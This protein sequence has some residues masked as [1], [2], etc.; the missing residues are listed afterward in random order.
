MSIS[1][2]WEI[3]AQLSKTATLYYLLLQ[4]GFSRML[5]TNRLALLFRNSL[6]ILMSSTLLDSISKTV[7]LLRE[8]PIFLIAL[9]LAVRIFNESPPVNPREVSSLSLMVSTLRFS[10][11]CRKYLSLLLFIFYV[12]IYLL[13]F[14]EGA[15]RANW[16]RLT[17]FDWHSHLDSAGRI[18]YS[19]CGLTGRYL[20]WSWMIGPANW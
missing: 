18:K 4:T 13:K 3:S 14:A 17:R 2:I 8:R 10:G 12:S 16:N 7:R 1:S 11:Q 15:A 5:Q 19:S 6:T 20:L 9:F